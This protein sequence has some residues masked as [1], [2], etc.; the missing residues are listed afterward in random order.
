MDLMYKTLV[1]IKLMHEY[2][3][4]KEDGTNLFSEPDPLKRLD[5]LG[6]L[7]AVDRPAMDTDIGFDFPEAL[8]SSMQDYGL[9][10]IPSYGG[11]K[12]AI[13]VNKIVLADNSVVYEPFFSLPSP[14]TIF[15]LFVKKNNL[16]EIYSNERIARS[17]PA[18]YTFSNE[19]IP[20]SRQYPF[21][22]NTISAFDA[23][24]FYEQGQLAID[25]SSN[26]QEYFYDGTGA[27]QPNP[28][29]GGVQS[30][31][32]ENDRMLLPLGFY[33]RPTGKTPVTQLD[34]TLNDSASNPVKTFS[35]NQ[36]EP[37]DKVF[38]DFSDKASQLILSDTLSL[39][40]GIFSLQ[41]LGSN[42]YS[43]NKNVIFSDSC[44][45][46]SNWGMAYLKTR[47]TNPQF[48]LIADDGYI[49][50]RLDGAGNLT[51]APVF[52]IPV[53]SRYGNFR[54]S[55]ANGKELKLN[56]ALTNYLVKE[57]KALISLLPVPLCKYYFLVPEDG[58]G[59]PKYLP[60]PRSFDIK[61]DKF[62]RLFFDIPVP[63]SDLFPVMP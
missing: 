45:S 54:Y 42:G 36:T 17:V 24:F 5:L 27:L 34:I 13:R 4:T 30:F 35:F 60:N 26:L 55:N 43:E 20:D 48:N 57:D 46:V 33:Y 3:L 11:C 16:P 38:L 39:P 47:V 37:I 49:I 1:E 9:K 41:V 44:Y 8:Q 22:V 32:N 21:L 7:F 58:G 15:I 14:L 29:T 23:G 25:S 18:L 10:V 51:E 61:K 28:V 62:Q 31:A 12:I 6:Q 59:P 40:T 63:E 19:N 2:F 53:K 52:E 56:P 50:K